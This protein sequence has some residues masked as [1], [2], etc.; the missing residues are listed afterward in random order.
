[1]LVGALYLFSQL[2]GC[3]Y[4]LPRLNLPHGGNEL[5]AELGEVIQAVNFG[6]YILLALAL[7]EEGY[8]MLRAVE[9]E[10]ADNLVLVVVAQDVE[11]A[12]G[13]ALGN[14]LSVD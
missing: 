13:V 7:V 3:W 12:R 2:T 1:M 14:A 5:V 8:V 6:F 10:A 9:S 11:V 4:G